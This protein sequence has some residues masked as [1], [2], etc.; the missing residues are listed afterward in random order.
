[1]S[2]HVTSIVSIISHIIS[3]HIRSYII[4]YI[5]IIS[6]L[7]SSQRLLNRSYKHL[8]NISE[9][10]VEISCSSPY[11][12]LNTAWADRLEPLWHYAEHYQTFSNVAMLSCTTSCKGSFQTTAKCHHSQWHIID[13]CRLVDIDIML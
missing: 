12:S 2:Y 13:S 7:T 4:S 8:L 5:I 3:H 1:M 10:L 9:S 11:A 6:P